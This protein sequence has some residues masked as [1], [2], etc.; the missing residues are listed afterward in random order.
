MSETADLDACL[1]HILGQIRQDRF[2]GRGAPEVSVSEATVV[3]PDGTLSGEIRVHVTT[4]AG[5]KVLLEAAPL[6]AVSSQSELEDA[7]A[8]VL[9]RVLAKHHTWPR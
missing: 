3:A 6:D 5:E 2:G 7:F 9:S 8:D 1:A 4:A